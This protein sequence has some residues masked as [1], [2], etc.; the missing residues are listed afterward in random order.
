M[1]SHKIKYK[2]TSNYFTETLGRDSFFY[3]FD[4][5]EL[6]KKP[7]RINFAPYDPF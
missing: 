1:L 6:I 3:F 2:I 7:P 5:P 4:I